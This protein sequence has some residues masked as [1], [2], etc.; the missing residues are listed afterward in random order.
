MGIYS[1][2]SCIF[3]FIC[4]T[5][6]N[7]TGNKSNFSELTIMAIVIFVVWV[8]FSDICSCDFYMHCSL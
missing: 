3:L 4:G 5:C 7:E 1:I 8:Q 6:D 2:C